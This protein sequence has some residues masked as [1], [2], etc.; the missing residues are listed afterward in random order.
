MGRNRRDGNPRV[1]D[2][3]PYDNEQSFSGSQFDRMEMDKPF[4]LQNRESYNN[5]TNNNLRAKPVA[6][7]S[8]RMSSYLHE[9]FSRSSSLKTKTPEQIAFDEE[10]AKWEASFQSWREEFAHKCHDREF[11][12]YERK[13]LNVREKLLEKR[14][15]IYNQNSFASEFENQLSAADAMAK[16]ILSKFNEPVNYGGGFSNNMRNNASS[17]SNSMSR[18]NMYNNNDERAAANLL[19]SLIQGLSQTNMFQSQQQMMMQ[20]G[21]YGNYPRNM[22]MDYRRGGDRGRFRNDFERRNFNRRNNNRDSIGP[23]KKNDT[24]KN[25][26]KSVNDRLKKGEEAP[27]IQFIERIKMLYENAKKAELP[28]MLSGA[29]NKRYKIVKQKQEKEP[30]KLTEEDKLF[31]EFVDYVFNKRKAYHLQKK[32]REEAEKADDENKTENENKDVEMTSST[33]ER[34]IEKTIDAM[35]VEATEKLDEDALLS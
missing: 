29:A 8:S 14:K 19:N 10:F 11:Q 18:N 33:Q 17:R 20:G 34:E 6:S 9:N 16:S 25:K 31:I 32:Q 1:W 5:N 26:K 30:E 27:K 2:R 3:N 23:K 28:K 24:N 22:N 12:E 15:Q 7:T 13:F 35:E 4:Y 21:N